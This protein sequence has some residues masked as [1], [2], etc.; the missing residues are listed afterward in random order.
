M[1]PRTSYDN[2]QIT[3]SNKN[4]SLL[5][6][7]MMIQISVP[8]LIIWTRN[9]MNWITVKH[10]GCLRT[11]D[12]HTKNQ[13]VQKLN[14]EKNYNLYHD[15]IHPV[16]QLASLWA[17]KILKLAHELIFWKCKNNKLVPSNWTVLSS[18]TFLC[19]NA[20]L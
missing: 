13:E 3:I 7:H 16:R 1:K 18:N 9:C 2:Y 14:T 6:H 11:L 19:N 8:Q 20:V 10:Q 17:Y 5:N 4:R 15:G 12:T